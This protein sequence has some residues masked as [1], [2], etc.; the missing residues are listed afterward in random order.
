MSTPRLEYRVL[1]IDSVTILLLQHDA[2]A[3]ILAAAWIESD[4]PIGWNN[5]DSVVSLL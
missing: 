1:K 2:V 3:S 4:A 5:C